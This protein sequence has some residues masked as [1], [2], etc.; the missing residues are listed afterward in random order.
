MLKG[1]EHGTCLCLYFYSPNFVDFTHVFC[2][3]DQNV[4]FHND[5]LSQ[6]VFVSNVVCCMMS[7]HMLSELHYH[8]LYGVVVV[9]TALFTMVLLFCTVF[10][11]SI[12]CSCFPSTLCLRILSIHILDILMII[13]LENSG[14]LSLILAV[15]SLSWVEVC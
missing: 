5:S 13:V 15:G 11:I 4:K 12:F 10:N 2:Y 6:S 8:C 9:F 1:L 14:E 3:R 7:C